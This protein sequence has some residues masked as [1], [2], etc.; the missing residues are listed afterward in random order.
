RAWETI[1][2][3]AGDGALVD[4]RGAEVAP[5]DLAEPGGVLHPERAVESQTSP[6]PRD[7]LRARL[8]GIASQDEERWVARQEVDREEEDGRDHPEQDRGQAEPAE[9]IGRHRRASSAL[10]LD[11]ALPERALGRDPSIPEGEHVA[12][13]DLVARAA[14]GRAARDPL[15]DRDVRMDV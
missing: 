12:A 14:V 15:D 6:D 1:R 10:R 2:Q 8:G 7:L 3:I 13:V 5:R 11:H 4:Q 9:K